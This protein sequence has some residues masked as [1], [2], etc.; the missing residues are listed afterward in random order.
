MEK[1]VYYPTKNNMISLYRK[2]VYRAWLLKYIKADKKIL[3][4]Y[5]CS[6]AYDIISECM[7]GADI[8]SCPLM[9]WN[10]VYGSD[11]IFK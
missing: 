6:Y 7:S 11:S 10:I 3:T 8:T 4:Y 5:D 1:I 9:A 2:T